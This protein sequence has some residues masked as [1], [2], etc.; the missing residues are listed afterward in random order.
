MSNGAVCNTS[1]AADT[2]MNKFIKSLEQ[3]EKSHDSLLDTNIISES[4]LI[5]IIQ[6]ENK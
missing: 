2:D 6:H 3:C 4:E 1:T 5:L